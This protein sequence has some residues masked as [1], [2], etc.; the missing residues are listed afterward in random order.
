MNLYK[1]GIKGVLIVSQNII[2]K[3]SPFALPKLQKYLDKFKNIFRL[4]IL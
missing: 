1:I 2:K 3:I 4:V